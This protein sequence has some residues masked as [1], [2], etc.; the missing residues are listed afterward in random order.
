MQTLRRLLLIVLLLA[1]PLALPGGEKSTPPPCRGTGEFPL[2]LPGTI[3]PEGLAQYEKDVLAWLQR[4]AYVTELAWCGDK[5]IRDTGPWINDVYYGTHK[6]ARVYYS[7]AVMTWLESGRKG[8]IPDGA[9][10][11]KEG[12]AAPA[13]RWENGPPSKITDWTIMIKDAKHSADGWW[14]AE[15]WEGMPFDNHEWP[16]QY[17]NAGFGIYCVRC[18]AS[19]EKES[20]FAALNNIASHPGDPLTFRVDDSWRDEKAGKARHATPPQAPPPTPIVAPNPSF[21]QTF[22]GLGPIDPNSVLRIPNE[23]WDHVP[24]NGQMFMTSDQCQSCHSAAISPFGPA[25]WLT[26]GAAGFSPPKGVNVSP[27]SEWRWSPMGLAGRDPIFYAQLDSEL[28]YLDTI[29]DP[30]KRASLKHSVV[31]TCFRCHGVMGKRQHDLDQPGAHFDLDYVYRT[32]SQPGATYGALS[33]DGISCGSCHHIRRDEI[34]PTWKKS[35]LE[36]FLTNSTTGQFQTGPAKELFGPF[37]DD[38]IV[39]VPMDNALGVKPKHNEYIQSSRMCGSCHTIDLPVVDSSTPGTHSIEQ[40]TYLEW[41]NSAYQNELGKPGPQ[42]QSCQDCHMPRKQVN[43]RLGMN[44]DPIQTRIAIVEDDTFPAAEH[45][46][47]TEDIRVRFRTSGFARH[48]LL[49]MNG[50]LLEMFKQFNDILG[51]R[52]SDYMTGKSDNLEN[53]QANLF[54]QARTRT[55]TVT[56]DTKIDGRTLTSNVTVTNLTGHRLPSGVGFRRTFLEFLVLENRDGRSRVV[57]SSGATNSVGVIVDGEGRPLPTELLTDGAYQKH[58]EVITSDDQVQIYE[59]L[60]KD[61]D[62]NFTTSFIRR[63]SD[64][65]DNRLL[66]LGWTKSGPD[67]SLNGRWLAATFPHGNAKDDPDYKSGKGYDRVQYR[68]AL[69]P[70]VDPANVT[71]RASLYYQNI[72]PYYLDQRFRIGKGEATR[73]L[74]YIASNLNLQGSPMENWKILVARSE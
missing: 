2:A 29:P 54:D 10:I 69:P 59:E 27:Y 47:P 70:D 58:H 60:T 40:A 37:K 39:T 55:A 67:P 48:E 50:F 21:L 3:P 57:W 42:A 15:L 63:D 36:F 71:V 14:W 68:I 28:S 66:P 19:A 6:A 9:M 8:A 51:V 12:I 62:G 35:P 26:S 13:A 30:A 65:K 52:K 44:V 73:R 46:A 31:D 17:P 24:A 11:I 43:P 33:R 64:V 38:E 45:R 74:Y 18:H 32:G 34:P 56:A 22:R 49:G 53:A 23:S 5:G 72:P 25:M 4:R 16:F 7:P 61:S 41:L 1:F 20:T